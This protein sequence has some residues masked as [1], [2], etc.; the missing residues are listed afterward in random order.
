MSYN[1]VV[2]P[3]LLASALAANGSSTSIDF[4]QD[5]VK[6]TAFQ[7][8]GGYDATVK[9]DATC[10][11]AS[12]ADVDATWDDIATVSPSGSLVQYTGTYARLR[13]TVTDYVGPETISVTMKAVN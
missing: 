1:N 6:Q 11:P 13:V 5:G 12:V 2:G 10:D 8:Y 4:S 9:V 3:L 7:S